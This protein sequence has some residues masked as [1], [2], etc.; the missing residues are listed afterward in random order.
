ML[1]M[2][3]VRDVTDISDL[4]AQVLEKFYKNIISHSRTGMSQVSV[5]INSRA[6]DI[7]PYMALVDGPENLFLS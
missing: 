5:A 6:A 2:A 7:E 1:K 4:V 3:Y